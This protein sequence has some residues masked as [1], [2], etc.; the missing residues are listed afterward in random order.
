MRAREATRREMEYATRR[1]HYSRKAPSNAYGYSYFT[2][3][4]VFVGVVLFS[5]GANYHIGREYGLFMG[6]VCEL[7]RVALSGDQG[8]GHT[9]E[10]VADAIRRLHHDRPM[11]HLVV[12]YADA[13]Q[14]HMGTIYQATNW[15]YVGTVKEGELTNV[16]VDGERVHHR[17]LT[18]HMG[19]QAAAR[20]LE[21]RGREVR[22]EPT[23]GKRKYLMPLDRATRR[24]I[25]KLAKP[26]PKAAL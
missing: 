24:R 11:L 21:A 23:K 16:V 2:E 25:M 19:P 7:V 3:G 22:L 14:G 12:S 6:E 10:I 8:H 4:G 15:V 26:Y 20:E 5:N 9:S 18:K 17:T 1:W 13:D